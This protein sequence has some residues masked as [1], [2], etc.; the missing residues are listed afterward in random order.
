IIT[1]PALGGFGG[2]L[3]PIFIKKRPPYRDTVNGKSRVTPIAPDITGAGG[4]YTANKTWGLFAF[5]A[6]TFIKQKI[7]Y[8]AAGGYVHLNLSFYK[9]LEQFGEREFKFTIDALPAALQ[10]IKRLGVSHWYAG[11]KYLFLRSEERRV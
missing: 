5:R 8:L 6:G 7:K 4:I 10:A 11:L 9:T 2:A 1:E 3:F